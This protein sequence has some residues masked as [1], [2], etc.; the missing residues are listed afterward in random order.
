MGRAGWGAIFA[1][2]IVVAVSCSSPIVKPAPSSDIPDARPIARQIGDVLLSFAAYD[3][4]V[5]GGLN[6]ERVRVVTPDRYAIVARAQAQLIADNAT[7]IVAAV[8]GT[9][10]PIHDRLVVLA[11]ALSELRKDALAYA[12]VRGVDA[13]ARILSDVDACWPLLHDLESLLKDDS[14]LDQTIERGMSMK[15]WATPAQGA[16]VTVGPFAGA[17]EAADQAGQLG[18]SAVPATTSPFVV[19]ISYKDRAAADA[20]AISLQKAGTPA[21]VIDHTS[22]AFARSGTSPDVELWREA[23]RSIDTRAGARKLALS[24][25]GSLV[26]AGSDDGF[27]AIYTN[28]GV[29][30]ALPK[31]NAGVNQLVFT[32]D[33]RFLFGGGQLMVTW[34]MPRPTF[35][36]GEPMRLQGAAISAVFVPKAY[37]FA[38]SSAGVIGARAPD[39]APLSAPFPIDTGPFGAILAASEAGELFIGVQAPQGFNVQVLSVGRERFPRG[40]VL[41]AGTGRAFAVDPSGSFG[42]AV[43]DQGTFR[44]S[45]KAENPTSTIRRLGPAVRDVEFARDGTLYMLDAAKVTAVSTDGAARWSQPL[46]D[47]RRI[48]VGARP[49]VL[50][51]TDKLIAFA[52]VDGAADVLSSVGLVQDLVASSDGRWI[53]VIADARRAVLFKLP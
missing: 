2:L 46:V 47:G 51:G 7:R 15:A 52:P 43:T 23:E 53:G 17:A 12:D 22:Y 32:G 37:A 20:A 34:L 29:L 26:A 18:P 38:A 48:V 14:A 9:A 16:L 4:A 44:F 50:D 25:D 13:L 6:G 41:L 36:V 35:Y 40:V 5:V 49:V 30:R 27:I 3:Y 45:L 19:R 1:T 28:D 11:D 33:G 31:F 8:V 21:I 24:G 10:G 42:A 39:G